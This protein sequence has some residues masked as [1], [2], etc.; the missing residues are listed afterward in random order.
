[1]HLSPAIAETV[2][3]VRRATEAGMTADIEFLFNRNLLTPADGEALLSAIPSSGVDE[4]GQRL[5][6]ASVCAF[7][8]RRDDAAR[9]LEAAQ[10]PLADKFR[11]LFGLVPWY[12]HWQTRASARIVWR[13]PD[14]HPPAAIAAQEAAYAAL[15]A[16]FERPLGQRPLIFLWPSRDEARRRLG[17]GLG[18]AIPQY[19]LVHAA[20]DQSPGHEL[21]HL[22]AH[23]LSGAGEKST[24]VSEGAAV[25][26]DQT[27]KDLTAEIRRA[28]AELKIKSI[29]VAALWQNFSSFH[30]SVSY[31]VAGL[32]C[33][34][35]LTAQGKAALLG[36]LRHQPYQAARAHFGADII[37][38]LIQD[39]ESEVNC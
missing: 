27:D 39:V 37:D 16:F 38:L 23:Y 31:P 1:M 17:R 22:F 34:R 32:F 29:D 36:L 24:F 19:Y 9:A 21:A 10:G 25:L 20:R 5:W 35:L 18:F 6:R 8:G 14:A 4:N 33:E 15:A 12:A 11:V 2:S 13:Y 30:F 26:L 7:L 28:M 3:L